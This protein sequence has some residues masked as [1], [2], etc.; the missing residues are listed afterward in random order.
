MTREAYDLGSSG[1]DIQHLPELNV[2]DMEYAESKE[3]VDFMREFASDEAVGKYHWF[4]KMGFSLQYA[5]NGEFRCIYLVD[6][7][8]A[9]YCLA[10]V[11][12]TIRHLS[13]Y[14]AL[15]PYMIVVP[16]EENTETM[17]NAANVEHVYG[18]EVA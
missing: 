4:E 9:A 15:E 8:G 10:L 11:N 14:L 17:S 5:G 18:I 13:G 16:Y 12:H 1:P 2:E 6:H 3:Q 7:P